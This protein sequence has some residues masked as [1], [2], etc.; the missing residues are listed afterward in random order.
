MPLNVLNTDI[1]V[2][3][4]FVG[5]CVLLISDGIYLLV[6]MFRLGYAQE[7]LMSLWNTQLLSV[8]FAISMF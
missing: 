5:L 2:I 6:N 3:V 4:F 1:C 8:E 7:R